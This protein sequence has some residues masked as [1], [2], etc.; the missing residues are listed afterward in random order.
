MKITVHD[1]TERIENEVKF[2]SPENGSAYFRAYFK[3]KNETQGKG[4]ENGDKLDD[5]LVEDI[6]PK[7]DKSKKQLVIMLIRDLLSNSKKESLLSVYYEGFL[8]EYKMSYYKLAKYI[9]AY[10]RCSITWKIKHSTEIVDELDFE[11]VLSKMKSFCKVYKSQEDN[12]YLELVAGYFRVST[13]VLINGK[14]IRY[15]TNTEKLKELAD[16]EQKDKD[17]FLNELFDFDF[18]DEVQEPS[19]DK[20]KDKE[21]FINY[22]DHNAQE[23]ANIVEEKYDV[24]AEDF[25]I[26]EE[27]WIELDDFPIMTYYDQLTSENKKIIKNALFYLIVS[28]V[29]E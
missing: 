9:D 16:K 12:P 4:S 1:Y 17:T 26:K 20:E 5:K 28:D 23:F 18:D 13:G 27:C 24:K 6:F 7:L 29:D 10:M 25:L 14:G 11:H 2:N 21:L 19:K 3:K 15:R 22:I 8:N